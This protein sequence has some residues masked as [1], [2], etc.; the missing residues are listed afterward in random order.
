MKSFKPL[1]IENDLLYDGEGCK[2]HGLTGGK[3][4]WLNKGTFFLI[5]FRGQVSINGEIPLKP[6]MYASL[7][8][9]YVQGNEHAKALLI[10]HPTYHGMR[11]MGGPL[12]GVG[13]LRYIDGCTDSLL[14]PPVRKGDPCLN[15]LHFPPG[16]DQTMHT[17]PSVRVG[18][19]YRGEGECVTPFETY[20]LREGMAF[21][22]HTDG[23]H[24][25]RTHDRTM[26]IVAWHPDSDTGP[27]DEDHPIV[28]RTIVDG[29]SASKIDAIRTK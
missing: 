12:E 21:V 26:D 11:M 25:F 17:H 13:R 20:P 1:T 18:L 3:T 5:L 14:V 4:F 27:T 15:H 23:L 29:V 8:S 22:I 19:V 6:G 7:T 2:V 10:Q 9:G 16:I 28:N 24:K